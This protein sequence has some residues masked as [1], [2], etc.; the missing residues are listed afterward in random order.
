[1]KVSKPKPFN[2][3]KNIISSEFFEDPTPSYRG[4]C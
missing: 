3:E 2:D 4:E 1:M